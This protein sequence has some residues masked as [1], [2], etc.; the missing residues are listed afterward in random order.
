MLTTKLIE[1]LRCRKN[2]TE[3][4]LFLS[5]YKLMD[6]HIFGKR[7]IATVDTDVVVLVVSCF[8][9]TNAADIYEFKDWKTLRMHFIS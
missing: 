1:F 8:H 2:K 5:N 7:I 9:V 3:F 6:E 4:I